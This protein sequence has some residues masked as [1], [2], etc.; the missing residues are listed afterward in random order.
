MLKTVRNDLQQVTDIASLKHSKVRL[1][2]IVS[3]C[4]VYDIY[5]SLDSSFTMLT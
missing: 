4:N 1:T 5:G 3:C 2:G